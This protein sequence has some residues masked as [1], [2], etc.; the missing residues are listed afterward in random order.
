MHIIF[1]YIGILVGVFF[2]GEMIMLSSIIAAHHG[3]LNFIIVFLIGII[4]TFGSDCF[5]FFLGRRKGKTLFN[6]NDALKNKIAVI[7]NRLDKY[8]VLIFIIYR[9]TYGF[10][11]ITPAVIGASNTKTSTFLIFSAISILVW[12]SLYSAIGY[13]FGEIIKSKLGYIEHI[14]KYI[15]GALV[16]IAIITI[17]VL[18]YRKKKKNM[19]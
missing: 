6:R 2:E 11:S 15:I 10:R 5:Y 17:I 8:P 4:G 7:E 18:N 14:E 16:S 13:I 9:F 19:I 3:Y 12:A 1:I